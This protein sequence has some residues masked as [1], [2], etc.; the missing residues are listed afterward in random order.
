M[1]S[2]VKA[3]DAVTTK[4][5]LPVGWRYT[6]SEYLTWWQKNTCDMLLRALIVLV[7]WLITAGAL[8]LGASFWFDMLNKIMV[9]RNT[10][11]PQEKSPAEGSKD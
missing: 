7:G 5:M 3:V 2:S 10:V 8:S 1:E 4:Y 6:P 11:K 9:I